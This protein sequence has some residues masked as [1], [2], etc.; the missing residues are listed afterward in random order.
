MSL[1][2]IERTALTQ[3]DAS[4]ASNAIGQEAEAEAAPVH[5]AVAAELAEAEAVLSK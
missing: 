3:L 1:H 5:E 4:D 2:L